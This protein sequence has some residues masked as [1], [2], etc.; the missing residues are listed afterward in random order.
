MLAF[1]HKISIPFFFYGTLKNP[2]ERKENIG[3]WKWAPDNECRLYGYTSIEISDN[4]GI[5]PALIESKDSYV[6]GVYTKVV[7]T[8]FFKFFEKI[9]SYEEVDKLYE[10][11]LDWVWVNLNDSIEKKLCWIYYKK[12]QVYPNGNQ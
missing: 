8:D 5:Y 6:S 2:T 10:R 3:K 12:Q 9:D 4:E 7:V 11:R 1:K